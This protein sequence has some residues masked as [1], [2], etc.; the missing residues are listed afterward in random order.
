MARIIRSNSA[1]PG[2]P[3]PSPR[4]KGSGH[5]LRTCR[6]C[7]CGLRVF[8]TCSCRSP[9]RHGR[10]QGGLVGLRG[11]VRDCPRSLRSP[12]GLK[13]QP[14]RSLPTSAHTPPRLQRR[15]HASAEIFGFKK[16]KEVGSK[17]PEGRVL[18]DSELQAQPVYAGSFV[19][20]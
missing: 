19:S 20:S 6:S 4:A 9:P 10:G 11:L 12:G 17:P 7:L 8:L 1:G 13:P 5:I 16:G 18:S 15:F 2:C 14:R 3:M